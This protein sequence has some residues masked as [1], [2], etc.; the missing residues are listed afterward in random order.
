MEA[1]VFVEHRAHLHEALLAV[2]A[3]HLAHAVTEA[4]PVALRQVVGGVLVYVDAAGGHLVQVRLPEVRARLL[5]E[6]H[7][8]QALLAQRAALPCGEFQAAGAAADDGHAVQW[9]WLGCS[10]AFAAP[11]SRSL[12]QRHRPQAISACAAMTSARTASVSSAFSEA[13][14]GVVFT[15]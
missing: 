10:G 15:E 7:I 14:A 6:R 2:E 4:V 12:W 1:A 9:G 11:E 5:D 3:H 8:R 13:K